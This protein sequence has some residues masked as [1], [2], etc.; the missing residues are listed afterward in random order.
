MIRR[1]FADVPGGQVHYRESGRGAPRP[2][3]LLHP[4]P[5]SG[6]MLAPLVRAMGESRRT[7]ALDTRGNGDS[8]ALPGSPE[9]ADFA[10]ATW[11]ALD[12]LGIGECDLFG[13][14]TGASIALEAAIQR[15]DRARHLIIDNMGLWSPERQKTQIA[16]NSPAVRPDMMGSQFNWA[17]HYCR[18]QFLFAPWY[19]RRAETRR[20]IDMPSAERLHEFVVEVLK[21]LDSYHLSYSAVA[22]YPK[23]D[24]LPLVKVPVLISSN[25]SDPL[26]RYVEEIAGLVQGA[27][28]E[29]CGDPETDEGAALAAAA[30]GPFLDGAAL[31]A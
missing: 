3:I 29:I 19:D 13:S 7:I 1:G 18:D 25:P 10:A 31:P 27:R 5:G 2:L 4:S 16:S 12:A 14:H 15:P 9:I 23:R 26:M 6:L 30:Y 24:R 11:Q 28:I 17:W 20:D 21:A 8:T 22:R